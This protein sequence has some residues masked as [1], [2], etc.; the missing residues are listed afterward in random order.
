MELEIKFIHCDLAEDS[1][2]FIEQKFQKIRFMEGAVMRATVTVRQ[3]NQKYHFEGGIHF[4]WGRVDVVKDENYLF[5]DGVDSFVKRVA[6]KVRK[7]KDRI[8]DKGTH[9]SS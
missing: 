6:A 7:E 3:E 4:R 8:Q 2:E 5:R 1:R 9:D